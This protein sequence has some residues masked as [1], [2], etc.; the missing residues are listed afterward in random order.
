MF[1]QNIAKFFLIAGIGFF[2]VSGNIDLKDISKSSIGQEASAFIPECGNSYSWQNVDIN[3]D[4]KS[5][6][7]YQETYNTAAKITNFCDVNETK[8]YNAANKILQSRGRNWR[9]LYV[10]DYTNGW[11][12]K[13]WVIG[14][15]K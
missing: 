1:L 6:C 12:R 7:T 4:L 14:R 15:I 5:W 3:T 9:F 11:W 8:H 10:T 2:G 13:K